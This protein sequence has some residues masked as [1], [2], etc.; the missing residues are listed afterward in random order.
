MTIKVWEAR[1]IPKMDRFGKTD[2]FARVAFGGVSYGE[3]EV[4]ESQDPYWGTEYRHAPNASRRVVSAKHISRLN[5]A[6]SVCSV[7]VNGSSGAVVVSLL[8]KDAVGEKKIGEVTVR[9]QDL[10]DG[11]VRETASF[12]FAS[13]RRSRNVYRLIPERCCQQEHEEWH[14]VQ[15]VEVRP[16]ACT[17]PTLANLLCQRAPSGP[18]RRRGKR[19]EA[20]ATGRKP[21]VPARPK[22]PNG[23]S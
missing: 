6:R 15:S 4:V 21:W 9:I 3:T 22:P 13:L 23:A 17:N 12:L 18:Y 14:K 2:A 7:P 19:A 5:R 11:T 8:D 10:L 20:R 1:G 16:S